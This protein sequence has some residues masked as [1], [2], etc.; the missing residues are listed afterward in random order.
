LNK[1]YPVTIYVDVYK[2][3]NLKNMDIIPAYPGD[4]SDPY[5]LMYLIRG[6]EKVQRQHTKIIMDNLNPKWDQ[7]FTFQVFEGEEFVMKCYDYDL[8]PTGDDLI[9]TAKI[10]IDPLKF[11][12]ELKIDLSK[13]GGSV[14]IKMNWFEQPIANMSYSEDSTIAA[15]Q[16]KDR[17]L[18]SSLPS[19]PS[20][21]APGVR[22]HYFKKTYF[23]HP[24]WCSVCKKFLYGV[25]S[26]QGY[27]CKICKKR[28]TCDACSRKNDV[29]EEACE[30]PS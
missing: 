13:G 20:L 1:D 14:Y 21:T 8:G 7:T 16:R 25:L 18:L 12:T 19:L 23:N 29:L 11:G 6:K 26:K 17:E 27:Q 30:G 28:P 2:A 9:G 22:K 5:I 24:T 10:P 4:V 15:I 3:E